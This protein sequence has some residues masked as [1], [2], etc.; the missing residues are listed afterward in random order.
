MAD[1]RGSRSCSRGSMVARLGIYGVNGV[2]ALTGSRRNG[3]VGDSE[4]S[5][6]DFSVLS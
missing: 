6:T 5:G 3:V 1:E 2:T 4:V